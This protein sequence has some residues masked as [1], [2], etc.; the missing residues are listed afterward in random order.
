MEFQDSSAALVQDRGNHIKVDYFGELSS[1]Q[2]LA[3]I[4]MAP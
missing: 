2:P 1:R 4:E 3:S